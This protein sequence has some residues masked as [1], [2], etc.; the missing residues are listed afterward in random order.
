MTDKEKD[1]LNV[2]SQVSGISFSPLQQ[3]IILLLFY[4]LLWKDYEYINEK[5]N[6]EIVL[7]RKGVHLNGGVGVGKTTIMRT[8]SEVTHKM[9]KYPLHYMTIGQLNNLVIQNG[10]NFNVL[11]SYCNCHLCISDI[12]S[13]NT[14]VNVYGNKIN[15]FQQFLLMRYEAQMGQEKP[16]KL[17]LDHNFAKSNFV[18]LF[19]D[20]FNRFKDRMD[21][22][23]NL[24]ITLNGTSYRGQNN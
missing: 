14:V 13:N 16:F 11:E 9:F 3:R 2:C 17:Y 6:K 22:M 15:V 21:E 20:E 24:F 18:A 12:G 1:L 7:G 8:V 4:N 5:G 19:N 10:G 23:F